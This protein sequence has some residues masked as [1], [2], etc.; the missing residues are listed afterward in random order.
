MP[1][2]TAGIATEVASA[3]PICAG[4]GATL[5]ADLHDFVFG[6]PGAWRLVRCRDPQCGLLW[7]D[8]RPTP[9]DLPKA[10]TSYYT[11]SD[12]D[13][14]QL[15]GR[16]LAR[17]LY[18]AIREA[19]WQQRYGY[20][21]GGWKWWRALLAPLAM[22][23]PCG[24]DAISVE[25]MFLSTR[26]TPARLLEIGCGHGYLLQ[27]MQSLG[28][29]VE[30]VEF[31]PVCVDLLKKKKITCHLGDLRTQ[32]LPAASF[33]AI[34][35]GNVIEHVYDPISFTKECFRVLRP[36]GRLV[37]VTPNSASVGHQR[38]GRDWRGLEPPRHLQIFDLRTLRTAVERCGFGTSVARTTN[39]GAFYILGMSAAIR[40]ARSAQATRAANTTSLLSISGLVQQI[41]GRLRLLFNPESGEELIVVAVK[42]A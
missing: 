26:P 28:W 35:T 2:E 14:G 25:A 29:E 7:L 31:D 19:W 9:E 21:P 39:R 34:Y 5:Y 3:C 4:P 24:S 38:F 10:Y 32:N 27:R 37:L 30:G 8:P 16:N 15:A 6:A 1:D 20:T 18:H 22:A 13:V 42:P 23:H 40:S 11:H 12:A 36:G 17:R 41:L 33:D